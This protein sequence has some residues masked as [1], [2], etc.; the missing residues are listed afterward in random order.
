MYSRHAITFS[1]I[2]VPG[3]N[4]LNYRLVKDNLHKDIIPTESKFVVKRDKVVIKLKK[5]LENDMANWY[6]ILNSSIC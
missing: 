5:V 1:L 4:G 6:I 3:L 2:K